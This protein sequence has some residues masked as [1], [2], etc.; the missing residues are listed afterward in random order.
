[1]LNR[2]P[3]IDR[4]GKS[5]SPSRPRVAR[6]QMTDRR[7]SEFRAADQL[8]ECVGDLLADALLH[9]KAPSEQSDQPRQPRDSDAVL[10]GHIP[11]VRPTVERQR[12]VFRPRSQRR[13]EQALRKRSGV[14]LVPLDVHP[15]RPN[16]SATLRWN[17]SHCSSVTLRGRTTSHSTSSG[18]TCRWDV[19]IRPSGSAACSV[20]NPVPPAYRRWAWPCRRASDRA[21]SHPRQCCLPDSPR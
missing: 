1:M 11:D 6:E 20:M 5:S 8:E 2:A 10:V 18:S 15:E 4:A 13:A 16:V 19:S 9:G 12:E 14:R 21:R 3:E 7:G 17:R